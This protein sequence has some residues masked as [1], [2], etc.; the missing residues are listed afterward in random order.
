MVS[1][2]LLNLR[3]NI[4]VLLYKKKTVY[5]KLTA[6][7]HLSCNFRIEGRSKIFTIKLVQSRVQ[8]PTKVYLLREIFAHQFSTHQPNSAQSTNGD[9]IVTSR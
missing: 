9:L 7:V 4:P 1:L 8:S 6:G 3:D 2:V 5:Q